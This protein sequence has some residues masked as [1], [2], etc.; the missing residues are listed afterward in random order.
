[1]QPVDAMT[2]AHLFVSFLEGFSALFA[3]YFLS[4]IAA[5]SLKRTSLLEVSNRAKYLGAKAATEKHLEKHTAK[6]RNQLANDLQKCQIK[7][8][9]K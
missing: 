7:E 3:A 6:W 1:M 2:A 9:S 8:L 4:V 5:D